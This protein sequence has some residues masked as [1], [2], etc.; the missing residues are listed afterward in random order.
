MDVSSYR[1]DVALVSQ[2]PRLFEGSIRSNLLLGLDR[3][4]NDSQAEMVEAC[5]RAEIHDFITSL[6]NGYATEL[7]INAQVSLSGGQKQRLCIARALMRNPSL[8]LL[9]EAMSSLDSESEHLIQKSLEDLAG[10]RNMIIIAVAHR[11]ATIQKADRIY[12]FGEGKRP[13][14]SRIVEQGTHQELLTNRGL[15]FQ[16]AQAL[17]M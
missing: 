9:D 10:K 15:Y 3:S 8:L 17:D 7:G 5:R 14:G 1:R 11:L 2:E 13:Q 6:P 12:V 4:E 16:M